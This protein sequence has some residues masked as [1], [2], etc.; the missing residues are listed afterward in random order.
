M[1]QGS[2][3]QFGDED[4]DEPV[5]L[6]TRAWPVRS[7]AAAFDAWQRSRHIPQIV[8]GGLLKGAAYY[9]SVE[10]GV[11]ASCVAPGLRMAVYFATGTRALSRWMVSP[12]LKE[13]LS[14]GVTWFDA[15]HRL[16]GQSFTGNVY[17]P[18]H[19]TGETTA[20]LLVS[21]WDLPT[22]SAHDVVA[23]AYVAA[24]NLL[25]EVVSVGVWRRVPDE[26]VPI[27]Y[28]RSPG[29]RM[30]WATFNSLEAQSTAL[31]SDAFKEAGRLFDQFTGD[32]RYA[33]HEAYAFAFRCEW[34][35]G[36]VI[37]QP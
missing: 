17:T 4:V 28:Y 9:A 25:P 21:R 14:D 19:G 15:F 11:P 13:A 2:E 12:S 10:E 22:K 8:G 1:A 24:L 3:E 34:P 20:T 16:D 18:V 32:G 37:D 36:E 35:T 26:L 27:G 5:M 23:D 33:T 30:C 7:R 29:Q 31:A 6:L